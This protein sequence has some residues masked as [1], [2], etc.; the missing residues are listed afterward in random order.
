PFIAAILTIVGYSL[1]DTIVVLDR[2]RENWKHVSKEG[3]INVLNMSINQTLSRTI[4][5]SLTTFLPV[6]AL[7]IWGGPVIVNFAFAIMVGIIV[8]TYS[9]IYIASALLAEWYKASP[10]K[11]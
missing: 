7:F 11:R 6:T 8:G 5:T 10:E 9:S 4:N 2:I 1:N 3:I